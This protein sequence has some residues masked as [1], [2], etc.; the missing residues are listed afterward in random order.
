MVLLCLSLKLSCIKLKFPSGVSSKEPVC[1]SRRHRD[2]GF[3]PWVGKITWRRAW[4]PTPTYLPGETPWTEEPGGLES[5][6]S[7]RVGPDW[8]NLAHTA[9]CSIWENLVTLV[10]KTGN[11][12]YV[13][14]HRLLLNIPLTFVMFMNCPICMHT[15]SLLAYLLCIYK[16]QAKCWF[17]SLFMSGAGCKPAG[18]SSASWGFC[19]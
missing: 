16:K 1:Q 5:M 14:F 4:Q 18:R 17:F 8:G 11:S 10:K 7:Q 13:G 12:N 19:G 9:Q 2:T 6:A 3:I 15:V